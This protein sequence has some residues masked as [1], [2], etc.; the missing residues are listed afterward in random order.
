MQKGMNDTDQD[1]PLLYILSRYKD[2][3]VIERFF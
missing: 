3:S 1:Y 2:L